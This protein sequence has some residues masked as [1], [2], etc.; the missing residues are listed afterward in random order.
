[1]GSLLAL[2]VISFAVL[3][4][5]LFLVFLAQ[6]VLASHGDKF[7]RSAGTLS[8]NLARRAVH[9]YVRSPRPVLEEPDQ[10][11]DGRLA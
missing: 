10:E 1:M 2:T 5:L 6:F 7:H 8:R 9:L 11:A 3:V 4:F